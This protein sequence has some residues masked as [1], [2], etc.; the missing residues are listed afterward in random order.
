MPPLTLPEPPV[1][2]SSDE[3]VIPADET[4]GSLRP[5]KRTKTGQPWVLI[6]LITILV[7]GIATAIVAWGVRKPGPQEEA[8]QVTVDEFLDEFEENE[9]AFEKKYN[10]R[11]VEI[12]G[13]EQERHPDEF[14]K[15]ATIVTLAGKHN[16]TARVR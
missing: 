6:G 5:R 3:P 9:L 10:G 15:G 8:I 7:A 11:L 1:P 13:Y 12:I 16:T 14:V 2:P 4:A